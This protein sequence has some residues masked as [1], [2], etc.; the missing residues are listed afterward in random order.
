M[1]ASRS[2]REAAGI[3]WLRLLQQHSP[4]RFVPL[5]SAGQILT[6]HGAAMPTNWQRIYR[7]R[8]VPLASVA[9]RI[10]TTTDWSPSR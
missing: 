9:L 6:K 8:P 5:Q 10:T 4:A 2:Q 1:R 7:D 3:L